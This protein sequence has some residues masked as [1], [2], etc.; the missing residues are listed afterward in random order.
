MHLDQC[1][2]RVFIYISVNSLKLTV[3][4]EKDETMPNWHEVAGNNGILVVT[5]QNKERYSWLD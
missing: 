2:S 5:F 1:F 4:I 3:G